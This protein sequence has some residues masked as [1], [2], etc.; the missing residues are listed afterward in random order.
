[1]SILSFDSFK[2]TFMLIRIN[3]S[4]QER[5][6]VYNAVRFAWNVNKERVKNVDYVLA[7]KCNRVERVFVPVKWLDATEDNFPEYSLELTRPTTATS[8]R[9]G[10]VGYEASAEIQRQFCGLEL[11]DGLM[12][13]QNPIRYVELDVINKNEN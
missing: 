2:K 12:S 4:L 13:D 11:E 9:M 7:V 8:T 6:D 1:M 3:K 10:F 5:K